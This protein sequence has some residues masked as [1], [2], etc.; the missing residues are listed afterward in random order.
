MTNNMNAATARIY[1]AADARI[2]E[3]G[4]KTSPR[5]HHLVCDEIVNEARRKKTTVAKLSAERI[6]AIADDEIEAT[7]PIICTACLI[8]ESIEGHTTCIACRRYYLDYATHV[9][10]H[11]A[12]V[13]D[14]HCVVCFPNLDTRPESVRDPKKAAPV[15]VKKA[16]KDKPAEPVKRAVSGVVSS[17]TNPQVHVFTNVSYLEAQAWFRENCETIALYGDDEITGYTPEGELLRCELAWTIVSRTTTTRVT[18]SHD[19][20]AHEKTPKAR[21]ACR[22]ARASA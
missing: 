12:G 17:P 16:K 14:V 3:L 22:K 21:A 19:A 10:D 18:M 6:I 9:Q 13:T 4:I 5:N 2:I 1:A 7:R 20:C 15:K 11:V 8:N